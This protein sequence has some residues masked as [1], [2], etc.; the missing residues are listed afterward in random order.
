M[1]YMKSVSFAVSN[2][3]RTRLGH[4]RER[5]PFD[6]SRFDGIERCLAE[7]AVDSQ[8]RPRTDLEVHVRGALLDGETQ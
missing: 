2:S 8:A 5:T 3:L 1:P 6:L 7:P 4:D